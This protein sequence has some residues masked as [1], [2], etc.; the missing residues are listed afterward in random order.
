MPRA[1]ARSPPAPPGRD[2]PRR[3]HRPGLPVERIARQRLGAHRL[4]G[5]TALEAG[6]GHDGAQEPDL[7]GDR[8]DEQRAGRLQH[9]GER[10]ARVA[11]AAAEVQDPRDAT[12][13]QEGHGGQAVEDVE[14]GN[15]RRVADRSQVDR[16]GP[17][18]Q[19]P[20]VAVDGVADRRLQ[21]EAKRIKAGIEDV[22]VI[23]GQRRKVRNT[24]R[25][26]ISR[27]I[28]GT[29]LR[30]CSGS[31][32]SRSRR[33]TGRTRGRQLGLMP[34]GRFRPGFP[35]G[36]SRMAFPDARTRR[37]DCGR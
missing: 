30:S 5:D 13:G 2:R 15:A 35:R 36:P 19:Q 8:I 4:R 25:E 29:L 12:A 24:R 20:G 33:Q 11:A 34:P 17:G 9:R 26:R 23:G 28:Q 18:E 21:P 37:A 22:G 10:E 16:R 7:L 6:R 32:G 14:P 1:G 3:H 27:A 31:T